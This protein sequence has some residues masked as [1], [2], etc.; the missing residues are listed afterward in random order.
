M[1]EQLK[2]KYRIL[3]SKLVIIK[4]KLNNLQDE[5]N[6]LNAILKE[7]L[8]I[9]ENILE[10]DKLNSIINDNQSILNELTNVIIPTVNSK[11]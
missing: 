9:D 3:K 7:T 8:L 2:Q 6:D 1:D 4:N 10:K 5:Y 11:M